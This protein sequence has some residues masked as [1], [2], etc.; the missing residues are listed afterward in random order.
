MK[1][2]QAGPKPLV[3]EV[4][5]N[6]I[7]AVVSVSRRRLH[8]RPEAQAWGDAQAQAQARAQAQVALR[9]AEDIRNVEC[10]DGL[11]HDKTDATEIETE[12]CRHATTLVDTLRTL[13]PSAPARDSYSSRRALTTTNATDLVQID[14]TISV[15]STKNAH[16]GDLVAIKNAT[17]VN[18]LTAS[19]CSGAACFAT[20][21]KAYAGT[22][23]G[24]TKD[25]TAL[26]LETKAVESA[27]N[28]FWAFRVEPGYWRGK[29]TTLD[30]LREC[31]NTAMEWKEAC[32]GGT[33]FNVGYCREGH[34]GPLCA[35]CSE[36]YYLD[37]GTGLCEECP[38][39]VANSTFVVSSIGGV[40]V[41]SFISAPFVAL[42]C[43]VI[44][45]V[46]IYICR[47]NLDVNGDGNIDFNDFDE[48]YRH[49]FPRLTKFVGNVMESHAVKILL[50]LYQI[51]SPISF[52]MGVQFPPMVTDA[53]SFFVLHL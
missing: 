36:Y 12:K 2:L 24:G 16:I 14:Y 51:L 50:T 27:D 13:M 3:V 46:V 11:Q 18:Y 19:K 8:D 17:L 1:A 33:D 47:N 29:N 44:V 52:N 21:I 53:L 15:D 20:S 39:N 37:S 5:I 32:T 34:E 49:R 9:E 23:Y 43:L 30:G 31:K 28:P 41:T 7:Y 38:D 48:M 35:L 42:Y 10:G 40:P 26:F 6:A 25:P 45:G 22:D 4:T